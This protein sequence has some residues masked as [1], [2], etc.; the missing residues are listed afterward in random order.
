M[1]LFRIVLSLYITLLIIFLFEFTVGQA[2]IFAYR[3]L[4]A[5][6][7]LLLNNMAELEAINGKLNR[8]FK[9]LATNPEKVR[10]EARELGY[11]KREERLL[12]IEGRQNDKRYFAVGRI[13]KRSIE[14]PDLRGFIHIMLGL[15]PPVLYVLSGFV[16][17]T[18]TAHGHPAKL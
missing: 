18:E 1:R 5:Y 2:G 9:Q 7:E 11:F 3:S 17:K 15:L 8:E 10:L 6:H 12:K 14:R 4:A 16:L 13:M